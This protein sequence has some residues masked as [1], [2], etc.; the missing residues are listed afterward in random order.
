MIAQDL[1]EA[2]KYTSLWETKDAQR[3]RDNK[4]FWVFMEMNIGMGINRK[5][6][7]SP[8]DYNS[9]Q[10]FVE[11]KV[12]FH[13]VYIRA[14]KDPSKAWKELPYLATNNVIFAVLESWPLEW[15]ALAS[16]A[17]EAEKSTA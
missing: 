12:D 1:L 7:L 17:V 16:F 15:H 8:T 4:I 2:V 9:L 14:R 3:I 13:H 6:R 11:F 5:L 10:S